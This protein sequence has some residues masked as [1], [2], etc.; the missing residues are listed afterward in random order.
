M[1]RIFNLLFYAQKVF[2]VMGL[3]HRKFLRGLSQPTKK[4]EQKKSG[5]GQKKALI[6]VK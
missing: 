6:A 2:S 3:L 1:V 5:G 4:R